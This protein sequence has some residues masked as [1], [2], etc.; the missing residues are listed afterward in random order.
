MEESRVVLM[1]NKLVSAEAILKFLMETQQK[2]GAESDKRVI[3]VLDVIIHKI[4][5]DLDEMMQ[6]MYRESQERAR[7]IEVNLED[8]F[9][10]TDRLGDVIAGGSF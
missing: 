3:E 10:N 2:L 4:D 9:G 1:S 6:D 8:A 5:W 7:Q